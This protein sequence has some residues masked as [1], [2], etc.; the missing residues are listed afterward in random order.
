[1]FADEPFTEREA[2]LSL[3]ADAAW[4]A[5]QI[6]LRRRSV[7]IKRGQV[8]VSSRYLAERWKWPE[9][10]VRRFIFRISGRRAND[11]QTDAPSGAQ[12]D[13]LVDAQATPEGTVI[14]IRNYD[15][16][17]KPQRESVSAADA[18]S[19]AV[20][21]AVR[22]APLDPK[23]TQREE[24]ITNNTLLKESETRARAIEIPKDWKPD[25]ETFAWA[26]QLL[27]RESAAETSAER[28]RYHKQHKRELSADWN[29]R[30]RSWVLEDADRPS[31]DRSSTIV[32]TNEEPSEAGWRDVLGNFAANRAWTRHVNVYGPDPSS[33][34]CRA[35]RH[36]MVE[37]GLIGA[38][39]A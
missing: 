13:A 6:R 28:F 5:T 18:Q 11:A 25:D 7:D 21:D 33:P 4:K 32:R 1:M 35:P 14:T 36:L 39:A 22:D 34:A 29:A 38:G 24:E 2:F 8:L 26:V 31:A 27:G 3:V 37:Y 9:P 16:F 20:F 10:R 12:F 17:Q 19:D 15:D 23:S 30:W